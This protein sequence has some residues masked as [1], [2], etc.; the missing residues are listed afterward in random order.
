MRVVD[1]LCFLFQPRGGLQ[2][3]LKGHAGTLRQIHSQQI[4]PMEQA[5]VR[6]PSCALCIIHAMLSSRFHATTA[7]KNCLENKEKH[8]F[9]ANICS[10]FLFACCQQQQLGG[11]EREPSSKFGDKKKKRY[12]NTTATGPVVL[13][14]FVVEL[15]SFFSLTSCS[16]KWE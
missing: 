2:T 5:M 15:S 8:F 4:I 9:L 1:L 12:H 3:A 16:C 11:G 6:P 14:F 13:L 7:Q 10:L